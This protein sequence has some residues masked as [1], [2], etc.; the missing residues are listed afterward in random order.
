MATKSEFLLA[1]EELALAAEQVGE[2]MVAAENADADRVLR[3]GA[4]GRY[5]P[6]QIAESAR[7]AQAC[8]VMIESAVETCRQRA[9]VIE[10]YEHELAIYDLAHG[11]YQLDFQ[12][13]SYRYDSYV[14][15]SSGLA[16]RPGP[17]PTAP[18]PPVAPPAWA[19]VRRPGQ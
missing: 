11:Q 12:E 16:L 2:L 1:A 14:L 3:G 6:L 7:T 8:Q 4:L 17:R 18:Q 15:D 19:D 9:E 5:L 10:A 13:W